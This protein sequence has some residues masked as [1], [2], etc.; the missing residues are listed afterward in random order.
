MQSDLQPLWKTSSESS[1]V[2]VNEDK[3]GKGFIQEKKEMKCSTVKEETKSYSKKSTLDWMVEPLKDKGTW[4][5]KPSTSA[6]HSHLASSH[7][8]DI[9]VSLNPLGRGRK[10]PE[11]AMESRGKSSTDN[12][13]S[14]AY[15]SKLHSC[16]SDEEHWVKPKAV[17]KKTIENPGHS[18]VG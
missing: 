7:E 12:Q 9:N 11:S 5:S 15:E 17:M 2:L 8:F 10:T 6:K 1:D 13:A 14:L 4:D 3:K 16:N 18:R